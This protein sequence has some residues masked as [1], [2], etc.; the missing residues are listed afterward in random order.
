MNGSEVGVCSQ[1]ERERETAE[2]SWLPTERQRK[3]VT[4]W[5][6]FQCCCLTFCRQTVVLRSFVFLF[7]SELIHLD[8]GLV[9]DLSSLPVR[10]LVHVPVCYPSISPSPSVS[11]S[12]ILFLCSCIEHVVL[13]LTF[14]LVFVCYFV[15]NASLSILYTVINT[16]CYTLNMLGYIYRAYI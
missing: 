11:L 9:V 15:Y 4:C 8:S 12:H 5:T 2:R 16:F 13:L 6:R 1:K 10:I 14:I 7:H 3:T